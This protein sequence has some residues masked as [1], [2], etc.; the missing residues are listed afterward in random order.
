MEVTVPK[1][2]GEQEFG[3]PGQWCSE[4]KSKLGPETRGGPE[5]QQKSQKGILDDVS[6]ALQAGG[7]QCSHQ[8]NDLGFPEGA[9]RGRAS[10]THQRRPQMFGS[11]HPPAA[12][13]QSVSLAQR[14]VAVIPPGAS[15]EPS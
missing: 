6:L 8:L 3:Q 2:R 12:S 4:E 5:K 1:A 15:P 7:E 9:V 10:I 13:D 14:V 11:P